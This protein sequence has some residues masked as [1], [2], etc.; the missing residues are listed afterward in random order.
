M[1]IAIRVA[2]VAVDLERHLDRID[3]EYASQAQY[4]A[5][6]YEPTGSERR[7]HNPDSGHH[8]TVSSGPAYRD[9]R[10]AYCREYQHTVT[11]GGEQQQAYGQ[12]CRQPPTD[13]TTMQQQGGEVRY[14]RPNRAAGGALQ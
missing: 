4:E 7:W 14:F 11:I 3:L 9:G 2:L 8:G 6:E 5:L 10:G 13:P 1:Q 12:A